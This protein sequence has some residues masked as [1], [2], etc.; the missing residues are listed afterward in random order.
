VKEETPCVTKRILVG[1]FASPDETKRQDWIRLALGM[2]VKLAETVDRP[3]TC[4]LLIPTR[5]QLTPSHD[6]N[7]VIG[8]DAAKALLKGQSVR[9]QPSECSLVLATG[10][11]FQ[12]KANGDFLLSVHNIG[13]TMQKIDKEAGRFSAIVVVPWIAV[14]IADWDDKWDDRIPEPAEKE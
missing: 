1:E 14:D 13:S 10:N 4:V 6:I 5:E 3:T 7:K 2:V 8:E 12:K 11:T 9:L